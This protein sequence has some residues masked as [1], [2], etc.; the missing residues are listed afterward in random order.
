MAFATV[1]AVGHSSHKDTGTAL[2]KQSSAKNIIAAQSR[3]LSLGGIADPFSRTFASQTLDLT[4]TVDLVVLKDS[5]FGPKKFALSVAVGFGPGTSANIDS[6]LA[7]VLDLLWGGVNLLL[8][9]LTTTTKAEDEMEGALLLDV[10]VRKGTTVLELL[11]SEDQ[12]LLIRGNSLLVL[13]SAPSVS[14]RDHLAQ[15]L[16]FGGC[17]DLALDIVDGV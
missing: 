16:N 4:I 13:C 3:H 14:L 2:I 9:L 10:V 5:E 6:L 12:T 17:T 11:S 8:A 15:V 1:L 7:L